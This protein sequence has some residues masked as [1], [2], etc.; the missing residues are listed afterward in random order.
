MDNKQKIEIVANDKILHEHIADT[1]EILKIEQRALRA[2]LSSFCIGKE[3]G[4]CGIVIDRKR[5]RR[6][7]EEAAGNNAKFFDGVV[8]SYLRRLRGVQQVMDAIDHE[9]TPQG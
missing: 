1:V 6:L 4:E 3:I 9:W 2:E 8:E 5:L 7:I